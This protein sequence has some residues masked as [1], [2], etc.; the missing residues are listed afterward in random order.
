MRRCPVQNSRSE[1]EGTSKRWNS[2]KTH[3][4]PCNEIIGVLVE[5]HNDRILGDIVGQI[6]I[7]GIPRHEQRSC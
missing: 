6:N 4:R 1:Y 5:C 3:V 2:D 7:E